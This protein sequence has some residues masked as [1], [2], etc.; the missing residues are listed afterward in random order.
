LGDGPVPDLGRS[1]W[2]ADPGTG[3]R[4]LYPAAAGLAALAQRKASTAAAALEQVLITLFGALGQ[5][6]VPFLLRSDNGLV[7]TSRDYTRLV[8]SYGLR[9]ELITHC[10]RRTG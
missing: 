7:F 2:L 4:L 1:R 3:D 6:Q 8:P 9:Q 10:R 5:M